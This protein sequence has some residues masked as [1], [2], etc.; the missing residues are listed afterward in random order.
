MYIIQITFLKEITFLEKKN[1]QKT[2]P[3][4]PISLKGC[5]ILFG[6]RVATA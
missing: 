6:C 3:D 1:V 2:K 5:V 4:K